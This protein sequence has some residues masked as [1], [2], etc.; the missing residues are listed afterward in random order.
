MNDTARWDRTWESRPKEPPNRFAVRAYKLIRAYR[1]KTLLD[2]GTG[3]G[4]DAVYFAR[5]GLAVTALD[6]S[7]VGIQNLRSQ[8]PHINCIH[9]D[10]RTDKF[11]ENSFGVIYAHLS[12]HYF[13]DSTTRR[14]FQKLRRTLK[15][16]GLLFVKC[17]ST[18]DALYG[19]GI[20][21]GPDMYRK[22]H[23]RHFFT[24]EY[25]TEMLAPFR[26]ISIRKTSSVYHQYKS[27]FIEAI[28]TK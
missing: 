28:A 4:R 13:D 25:M 19:K 21:V 6:R 27:A 14:V 11:E 22:G 24:K 23:V 16:H 3:A 2:V 12:L 5:K 1:L 26:I 7:V 20:K 18:D 10:I 17:K 9:G 15:P 8:N